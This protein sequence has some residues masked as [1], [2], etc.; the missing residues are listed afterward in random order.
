MLMEV[1]Y[2]FPLSTSGDGFYPQYRS[3][4]ARGL[5]GLQGLFATL[6]IIFNIALL[7]GQDPIYD[8]LRLNYDENGYGIWTAIIVS[9][10]IIILYRG[11]VSTPP[12]TTQ[13][14]GG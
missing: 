3:N 5:G 14:E 1:N 6:S 12:P 10:I 9:C 2:F 4:W 11:L 13:L 7:A 8:V